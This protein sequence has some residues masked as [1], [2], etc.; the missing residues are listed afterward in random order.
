MTNDQIKL[1]IVDDDPIFRLGL[2][3]ALASFPDL[4]V[5]AQADTPADTLQQLAEGITPDLLI[6]ELGLGRFSS[7]KVSGLQLCQKLRQKYPNLPLFVLTAYSEPKQLATARELGVKGYC[8]KGTATEVLVAALRLVADGETYW[9]SLSISRPNFWQTTLSRVGQ[10]GRRQIK[11]ELRDIEY[12]LA[13]EELSLLDQLFWSG[14]K[15]E[16][17]AARWLV[18]RLAPSQDYLMSDDSYLS[19]SETEPTAELTPLFLPP[20]R[21]IA[22]IS[23]RPI[24]SQIFQRVFASIGSEFVNRTDIPLEIDILQGQKQ[25]ELLYLVLNLVIKS[26]DQLNVQEDLTTKIDR[27]IRAIW[28]QATV[29]FFFNNLERTTT[30]AE[31]EE[32]RQLLRQEVA[33]IEENIFNRIYLAIDLFTYLLREQPLVIDNVPYRP[34]SPESMARVEMLLQNLITQISNGVMQI[35][36]NNFYDL[37]IFKYNLY[38]PEFRTSREIARFRNSLSWQYRQEKY[39]ENPKNI[40]T[41]RYRLF[42][43]SHNSIQFSFIYAPR[44][45]ELERLQGLPWLTTIALEVRD[46]V[47]PL[48]RSV[49]ASVGNA[50]IYF[51]T[52]VIGRGIG[53]IGK[54]I[55]QGVGSTINETRYGNKRQEKRN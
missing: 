34:E 5:I 38:Q 22:P 30:V 23:S 54:G 21:A 33:T 36:L 50:L 26:L 28:E 8:P 32:L 4:Q 13:R 43:W 51:L 20:Q 9:Q 16:L 27:I 6:L 29:D 53:L 25:Q 14:R 37:E 47:A 10:S 15:R 35:I 42:I 19:E 44:T 31:E 17:L 12:Y 45:E 41:S 1:F 48:L 7:G 39:W 11:A 3:T 52:Q 18:N 40:F 49:L 46:A 2:C 55:I 24:A